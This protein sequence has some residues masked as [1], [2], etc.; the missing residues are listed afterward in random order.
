M[1]VERG[2]Q[3]WMS[4]GGRVSN[5][6]ITYP[7]DRDNTAKVVLIRDMLTALPGAGRKGADVPFGDGSAAH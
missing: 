3:Q 4:S 6:W 7:Q 1:Q 5:T 2:I